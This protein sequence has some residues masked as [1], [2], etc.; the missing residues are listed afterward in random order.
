MTSPVG[1]ARPAATQPSPRCDD[2]YR[3]VKPALLM[4]HLSGSCRSHSMAW[5]VR[6]SSA[7]EW[8]GRRAGT[9]GVTTPA[10]RLRHRGH[11][12]SFSRFGSGSADRSLALAVRLERQGSRS[13][14]VAVRIEGGG[15]PVAAARGSV[16][17]PRRPLPNGRG[18]DRG[19][20]ARLPA[21]PARIA[22]LTEP[23]HTDRT[24]PRTMGFTNPPARRLPP[25]QPSRWAC[26]SGDIGRRACGSSAG[27]RRVLAGRAPR[28]GGPRRPRAA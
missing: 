23:W 8:A 5:T 25:P 17:A 24:L 14:T 20:R 21:L 26:R 11:A 13:L 7:N 6:T 2:G 16:G 3:R 15:G 4:R 1:R 22:R 19:R 9:P 18:S 12:H 28:R 10:G 27:R